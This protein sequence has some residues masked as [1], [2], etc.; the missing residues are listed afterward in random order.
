MAIKIMP[1][2]R[3]LL[4]FLALLPGSLFINA[5][6]SGDVVTNG[7]AFLVLAFCYR[8]I[9]LKGIKMSFNQMGWLTLGVSILALNKFVYTPV[10]LLSF[11]FPEEAFEH[12]EY[13]NRFALWLLFIAIV[14]VAIWN[15]K[16]SELFLPKDLYNPLF[17]EDVTLNE[18][19]NPKAQFIFILQNPLHYFKIL[20]LSFL[21]TSKATLA[22]YLGKFGWEKNY[23]PSWTIGLLLLSLIFISLQKSSIELSNN[24]KITFFAIAFLISI[25]LATTLYM[26]WSPVGNERILALSGRYFIPVLPLFWL[27]MPGVLNFKY[28]KQVVILVTIIALTVGLIAAYSRYY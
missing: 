12:P 18:G 24:A 6:I 11:L 2:N 8:Y 5:S 28:K 26:M 20:S 14:I 9:I 25:G 7:V 1:A 15:I 22:H 3:W 13:R 21:E 23:L 10:L 17:K 16:I 27:G 19:V 4:T